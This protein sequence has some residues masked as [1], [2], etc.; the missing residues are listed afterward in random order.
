MRV[1]RKTGEDLNWNAKLV[2]DWDRDDFHHKDAMAA[3]AEDI[4]ELTGTR[5]YYLDR[6]TLLKM[7]DMYMD[8]KPAKPMWEQNQQALYDKLRREAGKMQRM[9]PLTNWQS[10]RAVA[11][12][13]KEQWQRPVLRTMM[14]S[15]TTRSRGY[16]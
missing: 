6:E 12:Q 14:T 16:T 11:F 8:Y 3:F 2:L 9:K 15:K 10:G 7:Y 1:L 4:I 5:N 13:L